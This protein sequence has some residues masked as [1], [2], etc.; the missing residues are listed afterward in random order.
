METPS[1][2]LPFEA[3]VFVTG[4]LIRVPV[5]NQVNFIQVHTGPALKDAL[6]DDLPPHIDIQTYTKADIGKK[7]CLP[8]SGQ[9][10]TSWKCYGTLPKPILPNPQLFGLYLQELNHNKPIPITLLMSK[11][12]LD[13]FE[14]EAITSGGPLVTMTTPNGQARKLDTG[15]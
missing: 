11:I 7:A 10:M 6:G 9:V 4:E 1:T 8:Q 2:P 12:N 14:F 5:I 3:F 13:T 15:C